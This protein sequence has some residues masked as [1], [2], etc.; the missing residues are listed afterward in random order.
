M[1]RAVTRLAELVVDD[2]GDGHLDAGD[3]L[4]ELRGAGQIA[5]ERLPQ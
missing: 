4:D 1:K 3:F 2:M 5:G